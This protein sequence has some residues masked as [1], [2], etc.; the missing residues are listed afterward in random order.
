MTV[1]STTRGFARLLWRLA[2]LIQVAEA[3]RSF[4]AKA[5]RRALWALDDLSGL[6]TGDAEILATPGI[7]PG[8]TAL[9][10]EYRESGTLNQLI[11]LEEAYPQEA[12]RLRRLPRMTP[13]IL[14]DLKS[15][16][17]VET[18]ADLLVAIESDAA[19]TIRG[20]GAHT[21]D[22]WRRILELPPEPGS[23]PA[24]QAWVLAADLAAHI[25]RHTHCA[26][27]L[28]GEVRRVEE[29]VSRA[30]IVVISDH[31]DAVSGFLETSAVLDEVT[32]RSADTVE[33]TT[34]AGVP[35][36]FHLAET[37][38]GGTALV[39]GT[40][41]EHHVARLGDLDTQRA[42]ESDVYRDAG[43]QWIP[44][45][46][47]ILS[48]V[49]ALE[50]VTI[51]DVMGD[52]HLHSDRSPD[53]RMSIETI[54]EEAVARGY[55][56]VLITDH[57]LGLHF[58]G[59]G[60]TEIVEQA[61]VIDRLRAR[62]TGLTVF[63]GAELNI[64]RDGSLDLDEVALAPLDFAV[65]GVHSHFGLTRDEQTTRVSAALSH[66]RVRVLAHPL[67]R[68]IGIRPGLD[69]DME[70]VI[71]NAVRYDVALESNGHRDRLDLPAEW[72]ARAAAAGALFAAN[73]DAHRLPEMGNVA[74]AVATL[75]RAGVTPDQ[76]INTRDAAAL[77]E[78]LVTGSN[79]GG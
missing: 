62:F 11:P 51:Q 52:L 17:G 60:A 69:I 42:T 29:W 76:V 49:R 13:R 50:V 74:N 27:E 45:P 54:L 7:G 57:T 67:G 30:D 43:I 68:R 31:R 73:S 70:E 46:A 48:V 12:R 61:R 58:G 5:Y 1:V 55:Q 8:V 23:V 38:G 33:A 22:L 41:P 10:H 16:L 78:W 53:G 39:K 19:T 79:P 77:S 72:V 14:R 64:G 75:Q 28:A 3:R 2:D 24:H 37:E 56:Y 34:H 63:H 32:A 4:R 20:L 66:P 40:G 59:I 21:L 36:V 44:P 47:R 35:V 71:A 65:A 15:G 25:T 9:I 18:A 26:C 6:D